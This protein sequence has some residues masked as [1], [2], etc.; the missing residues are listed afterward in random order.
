MPAPTEPPAPATAAEPPVRQEMEP[1]PP[2]G[3]GAAEAEAPLA[4]VFDRLRAVAQEG[5]RGLYAVLDEGELL[6][7]A[8]GRLRIALPDDFGARRLAGRIAELEAICERV[9]GSPH[10]IEIETRS[11]GGVAPAVPPKGPAA[12]SDLVRRRRADALKHPGI[13]DAL[14]LLGG[15]I[16]DIRPLAPRPGPGERP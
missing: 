8:E 14:D 6:E 13:N 10:R 9:F 7:R 16:L 4:V 15:E 3:A 12:D 2:S 5:N 1:S 11:P